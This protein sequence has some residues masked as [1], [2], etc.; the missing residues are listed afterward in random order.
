MSGRF[1]GFKERGAVD[2]WNNTLAGFLIWRSDP[3]IAIDGKN[4]VIRDIAQCS[5]D[6]CG[7]FADLCA[8]RGVDVVVPQEVERLRK[9]FAERM[10][11]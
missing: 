4:V 10:G 11:R 1:E 6:M 9:V 8:V 3:R 5:A 2:F 7:Y